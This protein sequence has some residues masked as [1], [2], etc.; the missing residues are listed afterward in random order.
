LGRIIFENALIV[1]RVR[2]ILEIQK[3]KTEEIEKEKE[4]HI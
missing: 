4:M 1:T 2:I 3:E